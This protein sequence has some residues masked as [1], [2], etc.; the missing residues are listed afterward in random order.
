MKKSIQ[1]PIL[2]KKEVDKNKDPINEKSKTTNV[3]ILLNRVRIDEKNNFR[4]KITLV[5]FLIFALSVI[6]LILFI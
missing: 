4:K 3:N 2:F 6:G 1:D 5:F